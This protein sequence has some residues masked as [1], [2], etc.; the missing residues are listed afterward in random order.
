M[1]GND[2]LSSLSDDLL[3]RILR[4]APSKESASTSVLSRR[5][6]SL[7]RSSGAVNLAVEA[8][9]SPSY[10]AAFAR[11][12]KAALDAAAEAPVTRLTLRVEDPRGDRN[13]IHEFLHRAGDWRRTTDVDV[14]GDLLSHPAVQRVEVLHLALV[15]VS[16]PTS[17]RR[18]CE[19]EA[20]PYR[21]PGIYSLVSLPSSETLRVLD[22][23][24]CD[25]APSSA[26]AAFPRLETFRLRLCS[27]RPKD[28]QDI[29]DAAPGLSTVHLEYVFFTLRPVKFSKY[30]THVAR[31][32]R[33]ARKTAE[34]PVAS[35][36]F[37]AVTT[38]V[39]AWCGKDARDC[40]GK[41]WAVDI[42]APRLRSLV[43]KGRL[44]R[45]SLRSPAPGLARV[46]LH[47]LNGQDT[48]RYQEDK[49]SD[50]EVVSVMFWQFLRNFTNARVLKLKVNYY[51]K[52]IAAVG[53]GSGDNKLLCAFP[54]AER[55]ELEGVYLP[56]SKTATVAI[57][58]LLDCCPAV[59][60]LVLKLST[61]TPHCPIG[62]SSA[63]S[64]LAR[65]GRLDYS[66]SIDRFTRRSKKARNATEDTSGGAHRDDD[67]PDIPGLSGRSFTCL[68]STLRRV[69]LEFRVDD[70]SSLGLQLV[71]FFAENAMALEEMS[72]DSGNRRMYEH[73]NFINVSTKAC[74]EHTNLA[75]GLCKYS[76]IPSSVSVDS[77]TDHGVTLLP[78]K[79]R[80][81]MV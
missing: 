33:G 44:R 13:A 11:A 39:L 51:L 79:R 56:T 9:A 68:E 15:D 30:G 29:L 4:F 2:R 1:D 77:T 63:R 3:R 36:S 76:R 59:R 80:T 65:Q 58:N 8:V 17:I 20:E 24:R 67:V 7:S 5:W 78:L 66:K 57:V 50:K 75:E 47:I 14:V 18:L 49:N 34:P 53:E 28:L 60:D 6:R 74:F 41:R 48:E 54:Y 72:V 43:Y 19:T 37:R 16:S 12:A 38:L 26:T 52:E 81:R 23:T 73:L 42:D 71:K 21:G 25:L 69:S 31:I 27:V 35:L 40:Y 10:T 32:D 62:S 22:L 46:D 45:F 55:L 64:F 61:I 70:E